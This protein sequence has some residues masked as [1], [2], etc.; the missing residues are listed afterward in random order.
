MCCGLAC[1]YVKLDWCIKG[2]DPKSGINLRT[3]AVRQRRTSAMA[4]AMNKT[5]RPMWLTFHCTWEHA[6]GTP[7]THESFQDWCAEDGNS[8]RIGP[9]HHDNWDSL[10]DVIQILGGQAEHGR[11]Y[12]WNDP[13]FLMTGGAGCNSVEP[14]KRCPGMTET[15]YRTEFSL[16]AI[17]AASMIVS[18]DLRNM[19]AFMK[20]TLMDAEMLAIHQ[21]A[22]GIAGGLVHNDTSSPGCP[23]IVHKKQKGASGGA[24]C[25]MWARPLTGGRWAMA[26][27]NRNNASATVTGEFAALPPQPASTILGANPHAGAAP[28]KL[29]LRDIW[30]KTD[31]GV[32]LASF[33]ATLAA[34]ETKVLLLS[35]PP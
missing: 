2:T 33:A 23:A 7:G 15:E 32:H 22:L 20:A 3:A 1:S 5:G 21:D 24:F 29:H 25:Q 19:S 26:L 30:A 9:D 6:G 27:Y 11:P 35:P 34:H 28:S 16:W 13:D 17:G 12:R 18:T 31:L 8:W 14:G 4:H 10:D